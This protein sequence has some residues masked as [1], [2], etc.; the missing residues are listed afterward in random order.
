MLRLPTAWLGCVSSTE[1]SVIA[2]VLLGA[3][4]QRDSGM[5]SDIAIIA[6]T[7]G[8]LACAWGAFAPN[9]GARP[10]ILGAAVFW[11]F[12]ELLTS[13]PAGA[14]TVAPRPAM[15]GLLL[16]LAAA[17]AVC[18]TPSPRWR[19]IAFC[20]ALAV[21]FLVGAW[22][23]R[24]SRPVVDVYVFHRTGSAELAAGRDPYS[25]RMPNL[26]GPSDSQLLYGPGIADGNRLTIGFP[27]P[28]LSMLLSFLG[29]VVAGD[30]RYAHLAAM[31]LA[32]ALMAFARP[33][34]L[35]Y[36]GATLFLFTPRLFNVLAQSWTEPLVVFLLACVVFCRVRMPRLAPWAAGLF[37][38]SKQYLAIFAP[39][40]LRKRRDYVKAAVPALL[41][42]TPLAVWHFGDFFHSVVL[43][44]FLQP[45]R[46]D[47]LSYVAMLAR[48]HIGFPAWGAFALAGLALVL[49]LWKTPDTASGVCSGIAFVALVFFAFNK[50]AFC[51]YYFFV[52]GALCCAIATAAGDP[53]DHGPEPADGGASGTA[54]AASIPVTAK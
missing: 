49:V 40:V 8:I 13:N 6:V 45:V 33:G 9:R 43:C 18:T 5:Y 3:A 14:L 50:Q 37:F 41:V 11:A 22:V 44:Q 1:A 42:T 20:V 16:C 23:V 30:C 35:S 29:Y 25:V 51:N 47:A 34:R 4:I 21:H 19:R 28:P 26:Y 15:F 52:I 53:A 32:A 2:V 46:M 10:A 48:V 24:N 7:A 17:F 54:G 27:Y 36:I 39:L 12:F 31:T 38:A